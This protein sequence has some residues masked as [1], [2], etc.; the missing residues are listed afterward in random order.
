MFSLMYAGVCRCLPAARWSYSLLCQLQIF[1]SVNPLCHS[2]HARTVGQIWPASSE[3]ERESEQRQD[4]N[5]IAR[6]IRYRHQYV[7]QRAA[8]LCQKVKQK[9][10]K[11]F[12]NQMLLIYVQIF[13]N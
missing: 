9:I 6:L 2:C 4:F 1:V 5:A 11:T 13:E 7:E 3:R 8:R 12:Y 10:C